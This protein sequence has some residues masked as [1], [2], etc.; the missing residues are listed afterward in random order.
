[1]KCL[2]NACIYFSTL[3]IIYETMTMK[4]GTMKTIKVFIQ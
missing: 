2:F 1:M 3:N 4:R